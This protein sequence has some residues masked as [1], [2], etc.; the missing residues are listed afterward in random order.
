V[1]LFA[2]SVPPVIRRGP[3]SAEV[4]EGEDIDF[5]CQISGTAYPVTNIYWEKDSNNIQLVG[6]SNIYI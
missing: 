4:L 3:K 5:T 1:S 6:Q 2:I